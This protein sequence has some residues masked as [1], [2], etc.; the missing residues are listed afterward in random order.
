MTWTVWVLCSETQ[1]LCIHQCPPVSSETYIVDQGAKIV[2]SSVS[3]NR[4]MPDPHQAKSLTLLSLLGYLHIHYSVL[5]VHQCN[6]TLKL[7]AIC[8]HTCTHAMPSQMA[9]LCSD[10]IYDSASGLGH[11]HSRNAISNGHT[12][13]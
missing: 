4:I 6:N 12:L 13:L 7:L 1:P 5:D 8:R 9:T 11:L 2:R 3:R 10:Y